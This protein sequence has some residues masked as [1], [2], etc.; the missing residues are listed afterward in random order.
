MNHTSSQSQL[1]YPLPPRYLPIVRVLGVLIALGAIYR[2]V[3]ERHWSGGGVLALYFLFVRPE[4]R[5]RT[6]IYQ[7]GVIAHWVFLV[8]MVLIVAD[9]LPRLFLPR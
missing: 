7:I 2:V 8:L 3:A 1:W 5:P 4:L 9:G 6:P